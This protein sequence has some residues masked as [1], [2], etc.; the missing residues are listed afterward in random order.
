MK[1]K[2]SILLIVF[3]FIFTSYAQNDT[4]NRTDNK[5][6][7]QGYWKKYEKNRLI[8][9]G[10]FKNNIPIGVFK[11]YHKNGKL[12]SIAHFLN[13]PL[14]VKTTLFHDN[15]V[16]AAEGIFVDQ[17][18]DSTWNYYN[19]KGILIKTEAYNKGVK[20]G[21]W[22][23]YSSK[24]GILLEEINYF[25]DLFHGEYKEYY[26][27]GDIQTIMHYINGKRNGVVESYYGDNILSIKGVYHNNYQTGKWSYYDSNGKLRKE[28]DFKRSVPEKIFFVVYNGANA[29]LIDQQLIAYFQKYGRGTKIVLKNG[30][31]FTSTDDL[32]VIRDFID[33]VDFCPV[34]PNIIAANDAIKGYR[35]MKKNRIEVFL[36]PTPEFEIYS[37]DA[38]AKA[39][40]MLFDRSEIIDE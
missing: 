10:Q 32:F 9:E 31:I 27:N 14:K 24:T 7:K 22:C 2:I 23:T 19:E 1:T 33:F 34:T 18:K 4:L 8:Y 39:I 35:E 21:K 25:N 11:Y 15:G 30:K 26:V 5:G 17:I 38:E 12:K 20:S 29:Q 40:K 28:I 6:L 16:R 3:S 36:E 13:G 37:Q